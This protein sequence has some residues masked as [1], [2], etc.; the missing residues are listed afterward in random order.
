MIVL[1]DNFDSFTWNVYQSLCL[2]GA[3]VKVVRNDAVTLSDLDALAPTHLVVSPGPGNPET[4][5]IR[6]LRRYLFNHS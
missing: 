1:I 3:N 5:G 4:A 2:A 6:L